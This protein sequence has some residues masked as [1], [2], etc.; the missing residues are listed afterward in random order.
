MT[1][2]ELN[3]EKSV[4]QARDALQAAQTQRNAVKQQTAAQVAAVKTF[5]VRN[6][7][8]QTQARQSAAVA[9]TLSAAASSAAATLQSTEQNIS[10]L[11][12][13]IADIR[14]EQEELRADLIQKGKALSPVLPLAEHL[15]LYPSDTLVTVPLPQDK[16]I[17]GFLVIK[18]ISHG[19]ERQAQEM[20]G[21]QEK[22]TL[23]DAEQSKKLATLTTLQQT[24]ARQRDVVKQQATKART[25]QL[26]AGR[27]A[28]DAARQLENATRK[29][30]SLQDAV[31]RLESLES[32]AEASLQKELASAEKAHKDARDAAARALAQQR[33]EAA[34]RKL[35]ALQKQS[36]PGLSARSA[37]SSQ[38][39][40]SSAQ[41]AS[42]S[43]A[44]AVSS[45]AGNGPESGSRPVAGHI[46]TA[47]HAS[48]ESGPA[49]GITYR[50]PSDAGVR[51]P[52]T[53][54]VDFAGSFRTYGQM[55]ILNCG[56]HYR[57]VIAG[58]GELSVNTGQALTRGAPVGS[59]GSHNSLFVQLRHAQTPIN[60]A[61]FL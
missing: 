12:T 20:R 4:K 9:A 53:G 35:L 21:Q 1:R 7:T 48:T 6:E 51:A 41:Q 34:K 25:A 50:T 18:G 42:T 61:P 49:T 59:M 43:S 26:K 32:S 16:A 31:A 55:V 39:A 14:K 11:E 30:S 28:K 19:L 38:S 29:A 33:A 22:L 58:L 10:D 27:A 3:A 46:L 44:P 2:N 37:A 5:E 45:V 52:C 24:Q 57:F 40:G 23:L 54:Q 47:W 36:G 15:S 17:T 13:Q 8:A 60:P 56:K